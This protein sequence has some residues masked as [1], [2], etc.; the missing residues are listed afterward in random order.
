MANKKIKNAVPKPI[1]QTSKPAPKP[2]VSNT[3]TENS[4]KKFSVHIKLALLLGIIAIVAY[5]NTIRNGYV[6]DDCSAI[7]ENTIVMQGVSAIPE[8]LATPYRRGFF[9][10]SND[11]YRP[12]SLVTLAVEYEFFGLNP[13]PNHAINILLFG[14]CVIMLFF[15][16]NRFFEQK[17]MAVA[18]IAALLFALHPIHTEVVANIKSRDELLC[19]FFAFL[20][21]NVFMKYME[22]GKM[23]QLIVG[24]FCFFLS[25]L[26]KESVVT[27]LAVLPLIFFFYKNE[28]R[29]RSIYITVAAV[30]VTI[31]FLAIRFSVLNNYNANNIT[32]IDVVDNGLASKTLS[33]ESRLATAVLIL[34]YYLR[35]LLVPYPLICDY[36]YSTIPYTHFSDPLVLLSLAIYLFLAYYS[37]SNLIRNRKNPF[38]FAILFFLITISLFS[39]IPF[40]IGATM[41]ERFM[42]FGSVGFCLVVALLIEMLI[43]EKDEDGIAILK[44][45][46]VLGIIVPVALI[47]AVITFDRNTE[48]FDNYTLYKS[49]IVK[50]PNAGKLN[51]F[52]GLEL[53]KT[54]AENEKDPVKQKQIREEGIK[55]L[56]KSISI[57]PDFGD[58]HA[59]LGNAYYCIGQYDSAEYHESI[60]LRQNPINTMTLNNLSTVYYMTRKYRESL[61][62]SRR[63]I[64]L[65][66]GYV[67]AYTNMGRCYVNLGQWDSVIYIINKG[68]A[69]DPNYVF[70]YQILAFTYK[71]L[72]R[73]DSAQKYEAIVNK[74]TP[75]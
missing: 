41:G 8:I 58:A 28:N 71:T 57:A 49:D 25:F 20:S 45:P 10:T 38:A 5:A 63:A 13:A 55:Y 42:F 35:L 4:V 74:L 11:L 22:T 60:A 44:N 36:S 26:S 52:Y 34:G 59:N 67:N 30:L 9:I 64:A 56:A 23:G 1:P 75:H 15:F 69:V 19:F 27:F 62:L 14:G 7:S 50:A 16:L 2:K 31:I 72:G 53:E 66:P 48:W 40:L 37:I 65:K 39:N 24:T 70:S 46:I 33:L 3:E 29:K 6:L 32:E 47:Y 18:F 17:K 51:Y 12:L 21:L 73:L 43:R 61:E 54:I 68:I